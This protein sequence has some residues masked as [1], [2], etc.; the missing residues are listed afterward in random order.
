MKEYVY[1]MGLKRK[2]SDKIEASRYSR[3]LEQTILPTI[4]EIVEAAKI[5]YNESDMPQ[6]L[7][8]VEKGIQ[9]VDSEV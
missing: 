3:I 1:L 5:L 6:L 8:I 9:Y 4:A 2:T 7:S